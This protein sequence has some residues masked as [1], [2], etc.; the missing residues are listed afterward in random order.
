MDHQASRRGLFGAV[1][2]LLLIV[3]LTVLTQSAF[4]AEVVA[5]PSAEAEAA[6]PAVTV[7]AEKAEEEEPMVLSLPLLEQDE[8]GLES[9]LF[10]DLVGLR[11][12]LLLDGQLIFTDTEQAPL[13]E[14]VSECINSYVTDN[15]IACSLSDPE[16][17]QLC[18]GHIAFGAN[19]NREL[20]LQALQE[21]LLVLTTE[22]T[23]EIVT[24]PMQQIIIDDSTRYTE[25][26]DIVQP[27][28][29]G[30]AQATIDRCTI[31]GKA[32]SETTIS[33]STLIPAENEIIYRPYIDRP[34][35]IW[36]AEGRISSDFGQRNIGIGSRNHQG[37]DIAACHGS[38]ILAS[39]AGT[40]IFSGRLGGYGKA[41]KIDHGDGSVTVYAHNSRLTVEEGDWVE[42]GDVIAKAGNTG[43]STG[44]HLHFEIIIDDEAVDPE[45]LL[46]AE[47]GNL[48]S[49]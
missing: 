10:S 26:G 7:S 40:V 30:L 5:L 35:Y 43:V 20:A 18:Y 46:P 22:R 2:Y 11:Y 32:I 42:Q 45:L 41:V 24:I 19:A 27:G 25:E 14:L 3:I 23:V 49:K 6:S 37:L 21:Q 34:E 36:P 13:L 47:Q 33:S 1:R 15:T 9:N 48:L 17:L 29:D 16:Q 28:A 38:D 12:Y 4:A 8:P 31:N 44:T 39:K